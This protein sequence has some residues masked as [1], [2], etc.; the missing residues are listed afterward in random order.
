MFI[1]DQLARKIVVFVGN[2]P[3]CTKAD[4]KVG[5]SYA[6][7]D[8]DDILL[9]MSEGTNADEG[10]LL[11]NRDGRYCLGPKS[12]LLTDESSSSK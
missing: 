1:P 10:Y 9:T 7:K 6:D 2:N 11:E 4:I 3:G 12:H 8:L 5:V